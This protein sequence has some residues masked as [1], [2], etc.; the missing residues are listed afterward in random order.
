MAGTTEAFTQALYV[1]ASLV[2]EGGY[3]RREPTRGA[4][5]V[6]GLR[7]LYAGAV[8]GLVGDPETGKTLIATAIA[9]EGLARG[10]SVLWI[11]VDHNGP[12][13][14]LARLR[15]FGVPKATLT[16]PALFRLAVPDE[17][18]AV[19]HVVAEAELWQPA[20]AVVV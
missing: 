2:L 17:Q 16:D 1:D 19:L 9:A 15:R 8:N 6:D 3:E 14:T 5:R 7:L 13:A 20:L 4:T 11:D 12:A 18:S 10:E